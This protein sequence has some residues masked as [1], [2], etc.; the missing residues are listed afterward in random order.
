MCKRYVLLPMAGNRNNSNGSLNNV[1]TNGNYW[2]STVSST[3]SRNLKFNR[4]NANMNTNN[5]ANGNAVRCLKDYC[6][7]KLQPF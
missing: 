4:S 1:G 2:S 3:N 6:M 7:L 5:R